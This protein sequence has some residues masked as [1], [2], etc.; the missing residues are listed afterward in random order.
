MPQYDDYLID[1]LEGNPKSRNVRLPPTPP[2]GSSARSILNVFSPNRSATSYNVSPSRSEC[3]TS[4]DTAQ[5]GDRQSNSNLKQFRCVECQKKI[6]TSSSSLGLNSSL[7]SLNSKSEKTTNLPK[8]NC[9]NRSSSMSVPSSPSSYGNSGIHS[10]TGSYSPPCWNSTNG[11]RNKFP[12]DTCSLNVTPNGSPL[13]NRFG[14]ESRTKSALNTPSN[15]PLPLRALKVS[16]Q[17]DNLNSNESIES[18][19]IEACRPSFC[20]NNHPQITKNSSTISCCNLKSGPTNCYGKPVSDNDKNALKPPT[21]KTENSRWC[22]QRSS[23]YTEGFKTPKSKNSTTEII[24]EG[25][26]TPS[27]ENSFTK[28]EN[29]SNNKSNQWIFCTLKRPR[30]NRRVERMKD[31][32]MEKNVAQYNEWMSGKFF[33]FSLTL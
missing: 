4:T 33:F 12:R 26:S 14:L 21:L 23:S 9:G 16:E 30:R 22:I 32:S 31:L 27:R 7:S 1:R 18:P 17:Y 3:R 2:R 10:R 13:P 25:D 5:F 6:S 24:T 11:I 20:S 15:T 8:L 19:K 28:D 29:N